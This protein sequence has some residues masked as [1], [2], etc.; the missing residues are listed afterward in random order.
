MWEKRK[1]AC[2]NLEGWFLRRK[3][4]T[5]H[6]AVVE[7]FPVWVSWAYILIPSPLQQ[8]PEQ[9]ELYSHDSYLNKTTI[10]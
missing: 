4:G 8:K 3:M 9:M 10:M 7:T 2:Y 5:Q 6:A 1:W